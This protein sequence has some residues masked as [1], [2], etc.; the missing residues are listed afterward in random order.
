[1][2]ATPGAGPTLATPSEAEGR[3]W[4]GIA[5]GFAA[6]VASQEFRRGVLAHL[7]RMDPD[8]PD[9]AAYWRLMAERG[10]L[11]NPVWEAKWA[12]I[13]HGIALMT[14]TSGGATA[15]RSAHDGRVPVGQA[16]YLGGDPGR[17][18][19]GFYRESRLNRLLTARG[20]MLRML[21]ARMFRMM[22]TA[23]QPFNWGEMAEF[24]LYDGHDEERAERARSRIASDYYQAERR[25]RR[26]PESDNE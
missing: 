12:L 2:T 17:L 1:M 6:R 10:L 9:A 15:G 25:G 14:R 20:P 23:D 21:L 4:A 3:T 18:E 22:A 5:Y 19:V 13:L 11:S 24:I 26:F 7:R 16:L 8:A